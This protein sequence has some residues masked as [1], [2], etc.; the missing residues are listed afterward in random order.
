MNIFSVNRWYFIKYQ[1]INTTGFNEI[2]NLAKNKWQKSEGVEC[3]YMK[4][5]DNDGLLQI[6]IK[7]LGNNPYSNLLQNSWA[8]PYARIY[9]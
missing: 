4:P 5:N 8:L 3:S 7:N 9:I 6:K 1:D 2:E